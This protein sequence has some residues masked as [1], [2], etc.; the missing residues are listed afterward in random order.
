M[1]TLLHTADGKQYS[2]SYMNIFASARNLLNNDIEEAVKYLLHCK[3]VGH[4]CTLS[5]LIVV[6]SFIT[7]YNELSQLSFFLGTKHFYK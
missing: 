5:Y 4:E 7:A 1:K 2:N 6:A 3:K